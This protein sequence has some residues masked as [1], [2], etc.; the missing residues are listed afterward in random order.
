M[1][2]AP[3]ITVYTQTYNAGGYIR[4][5]I[6]SVLDQTYTNFE[7]I[8]VDHGSADATYDVINEY[9]LKDSRIKV[10]RYENSIRWLLP[11]LREYFKGDYYTVLDQ[12]DWIESDYLEKL[13]SLAEEVNA[14]IVNTGSVFFRDNNNN[15]K[16]NILSERLIID[17]E[18]YN[19]YFPIYHWFYR[20]YWGKLVKTE[21]LKNAVFPS[22]EDLGFSYGTDTYTAFTLLN[23]S[24]RICIDNSAMHHYRL[25]NKSVS[26]K[27][28]KNRSHSDIS[29]YNLSVK[30]LSQFGD[31][32]EDNKLFLYLVYI[33]A[34]DDTLKVLFGS[35][36]SDKEKIVELIDILNRDVTIDVWL[37]PKDGSH[38]SNTPG[39]EDYLRDLRE[40]S[41]SVIDN[42][43]S[44]IFS[45][46]SENICPFSEIE[47]ICEKYIGE[48][49]KIISRNNCSLWANNEQIRK[50]LFANE[51]T[52]LI[53]CIAELIQQNKYTKKFDLDSIIKTLA[54]KDQIL[55]LVTDR[56]FIKKYYEI[57][58]SVV[59]KQYLIALDNMTSI[60]TNRKQK[61]TETFLNFYLMLSAL[62]ERSDEF[63]EGKFC[64]AEYYLLN[65]KYEEC[66]N[67]INDLED[68]GFENEERL[69]VIKEN[70]LESD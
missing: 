47:Y 51:I 1:Q 34:I 7:Y 21:L 8:I 65:K 57:Y 58:I 59:K 68:M 27:Y 29:L 36:L 15:I 33:N 23:E 49:S 28:T 70:L 69:I 19:R 10:Y 62:L 9:K 56:S 2:G 52:D 60:I 48:Y 66:K 35:S 46:W 44:Y 18:Q 41:S 32:S 37:Y 3:K 25:H 16:T 40:L 61:T 24:H 64:I 63:V 53:C 22:W 6:D 14:D 20:Q 26:H 54:Q 31:I 38:F 11:I 42:I 55:T 13:L 30:F 50:K 17:R 67:T 43:F 45:Y 39:Y 5:C 4:Q 12:D